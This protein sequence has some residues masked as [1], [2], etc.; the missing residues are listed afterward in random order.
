MKLRGGLRIPNPN[1][2]PGS[3]PHPVPPTT[4]K[5]KFLAKATALLA[6]LQSFAYLY[7]IERL[8]TND[9]GHLGIRTPQAELI[10]LA[11]T[12]PPRP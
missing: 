11:L 1:L 9:Q 8:L 7:E 2:A 12:V 6:S 5:L 3:Q 10:R 4:A